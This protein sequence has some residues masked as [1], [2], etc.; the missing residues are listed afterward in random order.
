M[1]SQVDCLFCKIVAGEV[2]ASVVRESERTL[3]FRDVSP[4]APTHVLVV[5][6]EHYQDAPALA[7]G[8]PLAMA[9]VISAGAA[10]AEQDGIEAFR[11]V[12]NTGAEAGQ[13]VFHAHLHVLGG[14][15]LSWPPG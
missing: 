6:K 7:A 4:Q 9:E 10:V 5:P 13:S 11:L 14:R 3:A 15:A 8:D 1:S 2:P 12:F